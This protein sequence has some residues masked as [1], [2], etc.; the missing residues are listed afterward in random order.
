MI[1]FGEV[2]KA[3]ERELEQLKAEIE[4][5]REAQRILSARSPDPSEVRRV[6]VPAGTATEGAPP[7]LKS[8]RR[9]P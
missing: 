1:D 9:W 2:L 4:V 6:A 8:G 5:L 3:K 7:P